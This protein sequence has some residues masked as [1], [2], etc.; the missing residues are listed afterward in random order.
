MQESEGKAHGLAYT[1]QRIDVEEPPFAG[2]TLADLLQWAVDAGLTGFNITHPFKQ[3]VMPFLQDRS[4][5]ADILGAAN[6]VLICNGALVGD[7]TDFPAFKRDI[8]RTLQGRSAQRVLLA[9]AGG[10]GTAIALAL[11]NHGI[12]RLGVFDTNEATAD[13]LI[14]T[15]KEQ[16]PTLSASLVT[17]ASLDRW[18]GLVNCTPMGMAMHPGMAIDPASLT[19]LRW[20]QDIV[21][22]PL[23]TSLLRRA[24]ALG[25][26]TFTGAG[27]AI[28]QAADS[29]RLFTGHEPDESRL[30]TTFL[31]HTKEQSFDA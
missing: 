7:N 31:S 25:L 23:K 5:I 30:R 15:V 10:A 11:A 12:E 29:F 24:E 26:E 27:L 6:T 19:G 22:F 16:E 14:R 18:D 3:A 9:G 20:V 8:A 4:K 28:G 13:R 17:Q 21:Y 1:Y 2:R